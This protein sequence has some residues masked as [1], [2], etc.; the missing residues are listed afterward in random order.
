[1][2]DDGKTRLVYEPWKV[3]L[4][5]SGKPYEKTAGARMKKYEVDPTGFKDGKLIDND[6]VLYRYA[7]VLLMKCEEPRFEMEKTV[8]ESLILSGVE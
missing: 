2:L 7:D 3:E 1:M 8:T 6:I 4:D 5:V